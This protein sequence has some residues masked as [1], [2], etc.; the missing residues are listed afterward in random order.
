VNLLKNP[1]LKVV[2]LLALASIFFAGCSEDPTDPSRNTTPETYITTYGIATAPDTVALYQVTV[3]WRASDPDGRP[4]FYRYWVTSGTA[5]VISQ[6]ETFETSA[7]V[8]LNFV[9]FDTSYTFHVQA[10]DSQNEWDPTPAEMRIAASDVREGNAISPNTEA[11]TVPPNGAV[12]SRGI[13]FVV[14]GIDLDGYVP[15]FQWA[16]DDTADWIS[17]AATF[18]LP[19]GVSTL[20]LSIGP[21]AIT[22]GPHIVFIRAVDAWGNVDPSPLSVS[23][24]AVDG[25]APELALSVRDGES[26]VV[27]FTEPTIPALTI[28]FTATVDF[29]FGEVRDYYVATS[30]GFHD[31]TSEPTITLADVAEGNYWIAVTANDIGG[32]STT[33]T[34]G[35][36][37]VVL[38]AHQG[39]FGINGVDWATYASDVTP[40]WEEA[41]P[42][43]NFPHFKWWDLFLIPPSGGRPFADSVLG[44][45]SI[46][47]W[48]LDTTFFEAIV[49]CANEFSGDE[50]FWVERQAEIMSYLNSGGK[51]ILAT[52]FAHDFFFDELYTFTGTNDA[53]WALGV[54]PGSGAAVGDSLTNM[55]RAGSHSL[56]DLPL[57]NSSMT[58]LFDDPART[59]YALGFLSEPA[60]KGKFVFIGGRNYRWTRADLKANLDV[61]YRFYFGMRDEY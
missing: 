17:V 36:G 45:G 31:T 44:S 55:T 22:L 29:Y 7:T 15:E 12:T 14:N 2:G 43:G 51:L 37:V 13:P 57:K 19:G 6:V 49:W 20:E 24:N 47:G 32:N 58:V 30:A 21:S 5:T 60:G 27:P 61:I 35:F 25:F 4:E 8:L 26:F 50:A 52:R 33:D 28:N 59:D 42:F 3:Y 38:N 39:V 9:E 56:T 34:A 46:P 53:D 16:I 10:K 23:F 54:N 40:M 1:V 48:M 11:V 41:V 18:V